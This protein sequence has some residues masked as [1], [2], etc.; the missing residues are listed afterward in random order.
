MMNG[1]KSMLKSCEMCYK[2]R[3][4]SMRGYEKV[5]LNGKR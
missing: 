5:C 4:Y 2:L 3:N 1:E